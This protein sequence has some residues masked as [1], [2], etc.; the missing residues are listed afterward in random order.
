MENRDGLIVAA[1]LT[2]ATGTCEREAALGFADCLDRGATLGADKGYDAASFVDGLRLR[3]VTP[4]VAQNQS[5]NRRS[6]ID[7]RTTRHAGYVVSQRIRKR[8]EEPFGC[9]K[10]V[11]RLRQV[12]HRGRK[13]IR[14]VSLMTMATYNVIGLKNVCPA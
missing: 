6:A 2:P 3:G 1:E 12:M 13:R 10:T 14:N 7:G 11:G 4:H 5:G 9:A 8:I